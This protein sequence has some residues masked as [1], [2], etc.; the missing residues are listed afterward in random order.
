MTN[1][2]NNSKFSTSDSLTIV[3]SDRKQVPEMQLMQLYSWT[4]L[5]GKSCD[6]ETY[7]QSHAQHEL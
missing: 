5:Y 7:D 4:T 2:V 3:C 1:E 6:M